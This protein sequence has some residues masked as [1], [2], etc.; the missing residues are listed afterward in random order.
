MA[1]MSGFANAVVGFSILDFYR[2]KALAMTMIEKAKRYAVDCHEMTL[3]R[4]DGNFMLLTCKWYLI[5][6]VNL[7][8]WCP[9]RA[10]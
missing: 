6:R 8:T 5:Q 3:H 9:N 10:I 1:Y 4:Y 7:F 2:R